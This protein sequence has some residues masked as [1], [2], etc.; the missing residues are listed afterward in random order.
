MAEKQCNLL[1]NGGG[2]DGDIGTLYSKNAASSV[3][4]GSANLV[5]LARVTVNKS[6]LYFVVANATIYGGGGNVAR[7]AAYHGTSQIMSIQNIDSSSNYS[8]MSVSFVV[9]LSANDACTIS[10]RVTSG[11]GTALGGGETWVRATKIA[12]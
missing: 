11:S 7:L 6:G 5:E 3:S 2:I 8:T 10:G 12:E 4:V 9:R 1:K